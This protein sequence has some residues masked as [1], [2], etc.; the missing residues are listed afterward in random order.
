MSEITIVTAFFDIGRGGW[1]QSMHKHGGP[2]PHYLERSNSVYIERFAHLCKLENEII[3][4]TS[5][6]LAPNLEA[7]KKTTGKKNLTILPIS[8]IEEFSE[9]R[10]K[11]RAVMDDPAF[12]T[13]INPQQLRNPEYWCEDYVLVTSLKANFVA[14]AVVRGLVSTD[15]AA[16]ID[17]GYCRDVG[18]LGG[19]TKWSYDFDPSMIH[20]WNCQ[21]PQIDKAS[22]HI[23]HAVCNN[24]VVIFGAMVVAST[25]YW[26]PLAQAM[27]QSQELLMNNG[28]VDDD[29][30]L[31][32]M[33][34]FGNPEAFELHP[35]DY[36]NPFIVFKDYND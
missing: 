16:W 21:V 23:T 18:A 14:D 26:V 25:A 17:F 11:I 30:G 32:L 19:H 1:T 10:A 15:M 4:Y 27:K 28:L 13:K 5:E 9:Q 33:C 20:F 24:S 2:L 36:D 12:P 8:L 6:E 31:W 29:Q 35:L 34:Y 3:V 7:V 22:E